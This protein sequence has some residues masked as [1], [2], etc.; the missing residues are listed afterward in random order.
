MVIPSCN[1]DFLI[2]ALNKWALKEG[3]I[4]ILPT[5]ILVKIR[6]QDDNSTSAIKNIN[7]VH[8]LQSE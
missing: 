5:Q 1:Y 8:F 3:A 7:F 4:H 6:A 2:H